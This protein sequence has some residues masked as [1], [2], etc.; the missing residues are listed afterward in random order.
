MDNM[1]GLLIQR[2][3]LWMVLQTLC[4]LTVLLGTL[5]GCDTDP[6]PTRGGSDK[7]GSRVTTR[8]RDRTGR[9]HAG[10]QRAFNV[11]HVFVALCDNDHQGIVRVPA[12]LGNGQ[13]P[14]NNLYWGAMYGVKTFFKQSPHWSLVTN[15]S[16]LENKIILD[17]VVFRGEFQ[18]RPTYVLADAY[19][20][21]HMKEVLI[22]FLLLGKFA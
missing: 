7:P 14:R 1:A 3:T 8:P 17:R 10:S 18:D 21:A 19:D 12:L 16:E 13:D 9:E 2:K 11:V 22:D 20:G 6:P 15:N 4:C 5:T